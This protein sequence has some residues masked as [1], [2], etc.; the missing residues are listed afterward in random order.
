MS[1]TCAVCGSSY[2]RK[3]GLKRHEKNAHKKD[4][5]IVEK[6]FICEICNKAW[7]FQFE[8]NRHVRT[9][10]NKIFRCHIHPILLKYGYV[11]CNHSFSKLIQLM[12]HICY[13]HRNLVNPAL[14]RLILFFSLSKVESSELINSDLLNLIQTKLNAVTYSSKIDNAELINLCHSFTTQLDDDLVK[15]LVTKIDLYT[16]KDSNEQISICFFDECFDT[17]FTTRRAWYTHLQRHINPT[18][19]CEECGMKFLTYTSFSNHY[20]TTN[21]SVSSKKRL[22][23]SHSDYADYIYKCESCDVIFYEKHEWL[24]H[25]KKYHSTNV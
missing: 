6:K 3:D 14:L 4:T 24:N 23:P 2:A 12:Y 21:H 11:S 25:I 19:T 7:E 5:E 8:L 9:V 13:K 10:H 20:T 15:N 16:E 1:Y 17:K 18:Y 22:A